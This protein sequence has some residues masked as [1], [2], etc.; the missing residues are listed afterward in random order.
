[1]EA[2]TVETPKVE[3]PKIAPPSATT[4]STGS[5]LEGATLKDVIAVVNE[6]VA[7]ANAKRDRGPE[8]KREMTEDDARKVI[9]GDL[10]DEKHGKAG[11]K[12]GLS[13]GQVYG[14]RGGFTFKAV[15][16]EW[17]AKNPGRA[18]AGPAR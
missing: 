17:S 15:Y 6:L 7:K 1:M 10:K 11:E 4:P 9:F 3:A 2:K 13:Y 18:M 16:K 5:L 12:L 14:A 8:S